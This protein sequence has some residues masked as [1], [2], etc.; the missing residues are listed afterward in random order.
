M[1]YFLHERKLHTEKIDICVTAC[2]A[3]INIYSLH[4]SYIASGLLSATW[5][6]GIS[7]LL[8]KQSGKSVT[9]K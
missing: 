4:L 3:I 7:V 2:Q 9:G 8:N 1:G 5:W 6:H